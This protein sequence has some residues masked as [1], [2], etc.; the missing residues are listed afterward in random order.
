MNHALHDLSFPP[1]NHLIKDSATPTPPKKSELE[2][3]QKAH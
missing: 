3:K 1:N 2:W